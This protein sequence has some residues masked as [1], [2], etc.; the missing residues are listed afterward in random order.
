MV[1]KTDVT[2]LSVA[3][4]RECAD[5]GSGVRVQDQ[6]AA[7]EG[8]DAGRLVHACRIPHGRDTGAGLST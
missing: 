2:V 1:K 5:E 4:V 8:A 7:G 3:A 6:V